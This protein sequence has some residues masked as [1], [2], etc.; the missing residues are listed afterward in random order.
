ML[1]TNEA[2]QLVEE[3]VSLKKQ[4]HL[5]QDR[6]AELKIQLFPYLHSE[7]H[8]TFEN[9]TVYA[10]RTNGQKAFKRRFVLE[11]IRDAYGDAL[12][13]QVDKDCTSISASTD[14][15]HIRVRQDV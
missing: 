13:D 14:Q 6:E 2:N 15:V 7:G 4:I 8:I 12:A 5:L 11:Y 3:L 9:A 10:V 1:I